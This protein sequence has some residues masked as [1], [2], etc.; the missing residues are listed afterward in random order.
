MPQVSDARA[1]HASL[2]TGAE[3]RSS[4]L[5]RNPKYITHRA[6]LVDEGGSC[7]KLEGHSAEK[8]YP[9]LNYSQLKS[10]GDTAFPLVPNVTN[11]G[12]ALPKTT[13]LPCP[14][15]DKP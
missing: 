12:G 4:A 3:S 14:E 2:L 10:C 6:L 11:N 15:Q 5:V 7:A 13:R 1:A 8:S 9:R